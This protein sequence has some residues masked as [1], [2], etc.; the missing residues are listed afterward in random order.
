MKRGFTLI[1]LISA[2]TLL[3]LILLLAV[4]AIV[5]QLSEKKNEL[6]DT[7]LKLLYSAAEL[8]MDDNNVLS[9]LEAGD[10]YCVSL[11]RLVQD[12]YLKSPIK[13][14]NTGGEIALTKKVKVTINSNL[15][16]DKYILVD[17]CE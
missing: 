8:Y 12:K 6:S 15:E 4:P 5:N 13:D 1:E 7:T 14:V 16:Y 2:I 10:T 17:K 3:A 9:T 11:D